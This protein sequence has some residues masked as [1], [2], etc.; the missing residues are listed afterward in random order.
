MGGISRNVGDQRR[1]NEIAFQIRKMRKFATM[2]DVKQLEDGERVI[3]TGTGQLVF[4]D[5]NKRYALT[6]TEV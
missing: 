4:R 6:Y 1:A 5:G 2:P 3:V